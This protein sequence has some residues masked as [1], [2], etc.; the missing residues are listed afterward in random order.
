MPTMPDL[1]TGDQHK[2]SE[3]T[4]LALNKPVSRLLQTNLDK[5]LSLVAKTEL[6]NCKNQRTKPEQ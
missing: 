2:T 4:T 3:P 5:L 1:Q 6:H